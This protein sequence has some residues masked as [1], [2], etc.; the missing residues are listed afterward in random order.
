[1]NMY[2]KE[3]VEKSENNLKG[4]FKE[5]EEIALY[6]QQ[7]VLDAFKELNVENRHFNGTSGYGYD[8]IGRDT[9]GKLYAK[10]FNTEKA[11]VS[12]YISC[13]THALT[14]ALF[15]ILRPKDNLLVISGL[16]YDSI[17]DTM[18]KEGI[19]SLKDFGVN[20]N[21]IDLI[22]N[23]FNTEEILKQVKLLN[24]KMIYI[25]RSRGYSWRNALNINQIKDIISSIKEINSSSVIFVDNCYGEFVEKLEPTDVGADLM[26]GSLIKNPG[27]GLAPSG[28]YVV[29]KEE[30]VDLVANRAFSPSLGSEVGSYT[31]GYRLYYQGLFMAPHTV[32]QSLKGAYLLGES[33]SALGFEILP[34]SNEKCS[35]IVKSI[36]FNTEEQLISFVQE[37]QKNSPIDANSVPIPWEMPGYENKVIMAAGTFVSGA[38]IEFCCDSPI[39]SPYIA[40]FQGGLTYEHIKI[41]TINIVAKL[42]KN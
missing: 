1:M 13:G 33:L 31:P 39:R 7:K 18:F 5:L 19:G 11:L 15:G 28:G 12:P 32:L 6:N 17:Q 16:P 10:V 42:S 22:N 37:I 9:L 2:A 20:Y 3:L 4:K 27:G 14:C 40:Y 8:D 23:N 24:P 21:Q 25:Q 30:Y 35:D 26:I 41:A 36:K 38:S 29:G 34:K